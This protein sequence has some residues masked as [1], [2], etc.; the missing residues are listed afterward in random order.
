MIGLV[1]NPRKQIRRV[2]KNCVGEGRE[3]E[4]A[5]VCSSKRDWA[6]RNGV[7]PNANE[8]PPFYQSLSF[9]FWLVLNPCA[10]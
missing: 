1:V 10:A 4:T 9:F 5:R 2:K 6:D 8:L 7:Q 3:T